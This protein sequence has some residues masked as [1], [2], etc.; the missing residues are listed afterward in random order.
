MSEGLVRV[1]DRAHRAASR[2]GS[3]A[4]RRWLR[5]GLLAGAI[6]LA[7]ADA[8][9]RRAAVPD[10]ARPA[11]AP[12]PGAGRWR[13][14]SRAI[15]VGALV[16]VVLFAPW[17]AYNNDG[18]FDNPVVLSTGLGG[19]RRLEQ[20]PR[21]LRRPR[22][23]R[24]GRAL[25]AKGVVITVARRRVAAGPEAAA[26]PGVEFAPRARR[27]AAR[28][29]PGPAAAVVRLLHAGRDRP[30]TTC[31]S[32]T[33][34]AH[35]PSPGPGDRSSTGRY[36][37][38][39]DRRRACSCSAGAVALLPFVAPVV[40]VVGDHRDRVRDACGSGSRSMRPAARRSAGGGRAR[41]TRG[42]GTCRPRRCRRAGT[43]AADS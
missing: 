17:V 9:G 31:C 19:A 1:H 32:R 39:R 20:L 12:G 27:P 11:R 10:P 30:P 37:G 7:C 13:A 36:L 2:T 28:R 5:A 15:G 38:A 26:M 14:G 23:R 22:D 16:A 21:H 41:T 35:A 42:G 29:D 8:G 3:C 33:G 40:T 25:C 34:Q 18:R 24:V 4:A 43:V 6:A